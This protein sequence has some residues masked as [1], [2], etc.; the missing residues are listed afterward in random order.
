MRPTD[1]LAEKLGARLSEAYPH[2]GPNCLGAS[3]PRRLSPAVAPLLQQ[4]DRRLSSACL[5]PGHVGVRDA[6]GSPVPVA[7]IMRK[8]GV[9]DWHVDGL[10]SPRLIAAQVAT[11]HEL[12]VPDACGFWPALRPWCHQHGHP[13]LALRKPHGQ[14][15]QLE[16][17]ARRPPSAGPTSGPEHSGDDVGTVLPPDIWKGKLPVKR[18]AEAGDPLGELVGSIATFMSRYGA[19]HPYLV[20]GDHRD[21]PSVPIGLED[22]E[23]LLRHDPHP[24]MIAVVKHG[25]PIAT[26]THTPTRTDAGGLARLLTGGATVVI[27]SAHL[28]LPDVADLAATLQL[29]FRQPVQAN[30]YITPAQNDG[31]KA[32]TDP[33]DT[34]I[35]QLVG[36]KRWWLESGAPGRPGARPDR[37]DRDLTLNEGDVLY[38]PAG[39]AHA[40]HAESRPSIHLTLGVTRRR[41]GEVRAQALRILAREAASSPEYATE[42]TFMTGADDGVPESGRAAPSELEMGEATA[43]ALRQQDA[44]F[45]QLL[46]VSSRGCLLELFQSEPMRPRATPIGGLAAG[47]GLRVDGVGVSLRDEALTLLGRIGH[48]ADWDGGYTAELDVLLALR[49]CRLDRPSPIVAEHPATMVMTDTGLEDRS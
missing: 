3:G 19:G 23:Y 5:D 35:V 15:A 41:L 11:G 49:L 48:T 26:P 29:K 36:A 16:I 47:G 2:S 34:L 40:A 32:H 44:T 13:D 30:I 37:P 28:V 12:I 38:I 18:P 45:R 39:V 31:F 33:H 27:N 22:V 9:G 24:A 4:L 8:H 10:L 42:L 25:E 17:T 20:R 7:A 43:K 6:A 1:Q 14:S 21:T 46:P